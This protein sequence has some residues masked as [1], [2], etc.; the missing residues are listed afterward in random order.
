MRRCSMLRGLNAI[1]L[2]FLFLIAAGIYTCLPAADIKS[3][4]L[5]PSGIHEDCLEMM[6]GQTVDYSF[7]A[8]KPV[9]F[10]LHCHEKS[11]VVYE[12]SKDGVTADKGTFGCK[13][14]QYYCFMW[15]N[16]GPEPVSL[17]YDYSLSTKEQEGER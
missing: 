12:I 5:K 4:T 3:E 13:R 14:K 10:N 6:P 2:S 9:D 15:T 17:R 8:S 16:P 1:S 11:G 7:E